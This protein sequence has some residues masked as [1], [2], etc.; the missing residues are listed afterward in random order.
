MSSQPST[1]IHSSTALTGE[2]K[3][4]S[5]EE[6]LPQIDFEQCAQGKSEVQVHFRGKIYRLKVTRNGGLILNK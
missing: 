6:E 2:E 5:G 3:S 1:D 4:P